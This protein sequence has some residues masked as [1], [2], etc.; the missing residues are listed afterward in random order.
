[1]AETAAMTTT[2]KIIAI[3]VTIIIISTVAL[4]VIQDLH[5]SLATYENNDDYLR[6]SMISKSE[7]MVLAYSDDTETLTKDG[8][9]V[10]VG[11]D[12]WTSFGVVGFSDEFFIVAG[13][14]SDQNKL[15]LWTVNYIYLP[16]TDWTLT[17]SNGTWAATDGNGNDYSG[18]FN[19]LYLFD[20]AGDYGYFKVS[21]GWSIT[22]NNED[23]VL[24][25][26]NRLHFASTII[27]DFAP[28]SKINKAYEYSVSSFVVSGPTET[29]VSITMDV[30]DD[31]TTITGAT[32]GGVDVTASEAGVIAP[33]HYRVW[34]GNESSWDSLIQVIPILLILVPVMLAVRM[35]ALKRN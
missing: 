7:N 11:A 21:S 22:V 35:I 29:S 12:D 8:V 1:M 19:H 2:Q 9:P 17:L 25:C 28:V 20:D 33:I 23:P 34:E 14:N 26:D 18:T 32:I 27:T 13:A 4:P 24:F 3:A 30:G 5:Y 31:V 6:Y 16:S 15:A 10:Y